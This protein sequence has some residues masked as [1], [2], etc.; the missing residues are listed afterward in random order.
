MRQ[1]VNTAFHMAAPW[2]RRNSFFAAL[3]SRR[4]RRFASVMLRLTAVLSG[5]LWG[6]LTFAAARPPNIL[7]LVAD[8]LGYGELGCQGN[9][10]IPTQHIDSL[11]RN[12][13]RFTQGY[14]TASLCSP[15]RAGLLTGRYQQRFGHELNPIGRQNLEPHIGLP[16]TEHTLADR[17][18]AA[19]YVT[20]ILGK[21]H[22]G[23][24]GPFHPQRRGFDEYFGFLHEG[25]TR[26]E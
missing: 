1:Q 7:L 6:T 9:R 21:W 16:L 22:L 13:I 19:G 10:E 8:D 26:S 24:T 25:H 15:S 4:G 5:V 12:G 2:I 3:T 14:V 11:A 18:K 17:L 23:G 20:A